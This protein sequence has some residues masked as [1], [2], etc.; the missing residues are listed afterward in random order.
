MFS[1]R[2]R[3]K[4]GA[5]PKSGTAKN[6]RM[7]AVDPTFAATARI[8]WFLRE[9]YTRHDGWPVREAAS[10]LEVHPKT[11]QRYVRFLGMVHTDGDGEPIV[12]VE[13]RDRVPHVVLRKRILP[14]QD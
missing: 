2:G 7:P 8:W 13:H 9:L 1:L 10:E 4:I 6:K 12:A 14:F 11:I 5:T 3:R